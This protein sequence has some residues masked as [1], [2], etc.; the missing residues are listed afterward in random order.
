MTVNGIDLNRE[1]IPNVLQQPL[2]GIRRLYGGPVSYAPVLTTLGPSH[3]SLFFA[4]GKVV[5]TLRCPLSALMRWGQGHCAA[6]PRGLWDR[7]REM[8]VFL[9]VSSPW[10]AVLV[11]VATCFH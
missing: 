11:C 4:Y 8:W 6:L 5:R 3:N 1:G 10:G 2:V 9:S 7:G